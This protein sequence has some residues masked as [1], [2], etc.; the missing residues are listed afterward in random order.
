M[1]MCLYGQQQRCVLQV[2]DSGHITV[3]VVRLASLAREAQISGS[4][5]GGNGTSK[6]VKIR[7]QDA[8]A[9][10][11]LNRIALTTASQRQL[12]L[13]IGQSL[14]QLISLDLPGMNASLSHDIGH[15][16][17]AGRK[18]SIQ[19]HNF[20]YIAGKARGDVKSRLESLYNTASLNIT[21]Y[22]ETTPPRRVY[23]QLGLWD[24]GNNFIAAAR[25]V[26]DLPMIYRYNFTQMD[27]WNFMIDN[28]FI[29]A[30]AYGTSLDLQVSP[31]G[32]FSQCAAKGHIG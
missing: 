26:S 20:T 27:Q 13:E 5:Y 16:S 1:V 4:L 32:F 6:P 28:A 10:A 22:E 23:R 8:C 2:T 14:I 7:S 11:M 29:L 3:G 18:L 21:V 9:T 19:S 24:A 15:P 30:S 25:G 17:A 12:F 31:V